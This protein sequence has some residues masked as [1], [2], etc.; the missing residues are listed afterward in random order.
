[1][2]PL[3]WFWAGFRIKK[4]A[5]R[6]LKVIK[7]S[8]TILAWLT[9]MDIMVFFF[10]YSSANSSELRWPHF[11]GSQ[12]VATYKN[13]PFS[14]NKGFNLP[15]HTRIHNIRKYI[16]HEN[17]NYSFWHSL[18]ILQGLNTFYT[19][20]HVHCLVLYICLLFARQR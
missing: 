10:F 6:N 3:I 7:W 19:V 9:N 1:M 4:K 12:K 5:W 18:S 17:K 14:Q 11:I 20:Y 13:L 2:N 8:I 16:T 15:F